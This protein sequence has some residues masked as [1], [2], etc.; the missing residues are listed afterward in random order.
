MPEV[1]TLEEVGLGNMQLVNWFGIFAPKQT[2]MAVVATLNRAVN[3]ILALPQL[4]AAI[5][6]MALR[7]MGGTP[8]DFRESIAQDR[9]R[10][11][12]ALSGVIEPR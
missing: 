5:D 4:R 12:R 3:D 11:G 1:P 9:R 7:V 6:A 10:R 2:P 8:Q